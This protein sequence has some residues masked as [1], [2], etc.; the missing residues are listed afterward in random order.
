MIRQT[1]D[2][3]MDRYI[4]PTQTSSSHFLIYTS[5]HHQPNPQKRPWK[6]S[7]PAPA[8]AH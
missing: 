6:S 4:L 3:Y 5:L 7:R 1:A 2:I 8:M